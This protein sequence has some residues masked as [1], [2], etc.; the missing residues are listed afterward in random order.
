MSL[1]DDSHAHGHMLHWL[2]PLFFQR[3][4]ICHCYT[5]L[6]PFLAWVWGWWRLP[7]FCY[8]HANK[9]TRGAF[10]AAVF[11]MQGFGILAGGMVAIV[12]SAA[13]MAKYPAPSFQENPALS[14]VPQADYVWRIIVMFGEV[15]HHQGIS[16]ELQARIVRRMK[17]V[18]I[19]A[20]SDINCSSRTGSR[21]SSR[22]ISGSS[23]GRAQE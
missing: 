9:K 23:H 12:V 1:W 21:S 8:H 7:S 5:L 20:H 14:T 6:L 22:R 19:L 15:V 2:W 3:T 17:E 18:R 11:A 16:H 10:I 13:F 4:N